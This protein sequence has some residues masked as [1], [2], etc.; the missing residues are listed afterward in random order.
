MTTR[1]ANNV[2]LFDK[3][4]AVAAVHRALALAELALNDEELRQA[5]FGVD[6]RAALARFQQSNDLEATGL[7]DAA[8]AAVLN[9]L[10]AAEDNSFSRL[11]P[12]IRPFR[13][14][15][16]LGES[17]RSF[18]ERDTAVGEVVRASLTVELKS[19]L[20][21][22][23]DAPS[24]RLVSAID[25]LEI[26]LADVEDM[27]VD[28]LLFTR[29]MPELASDQELARELTRMAD[30]GLETEPVTVAE[31]LGLDG[32]ARDSSALTGLVNRARNEAL[33]DIV[34]ANDALV[35]ALDTANLLEDDHALDRL[36]ADGT[37][38]EDQRDELRATVSFARLTDDN[39]TAIRALREEGFRSA[40]ELTTRGRDDWLSF[41]ATHELEPPADESVEGY[42]ELLDAGVE[43]AYPTAYALDRYALAAPAGMLDRMPVLERVS[44]AGDRIFVDGELAED[45][46]LDALPEN[47]REAVRA[48]LEALNQFANRYAALGVRDIL[49]DRTIGTGEKRARI[50]HRTQALSAAWAAM[51]D[52]NLDIAN[53]FPLDDRVAQA[54]L[55]DLVE[56]DEEDRPHVRAALMAMQR[57]RH[58]TED[59]ADAERLLSTGLDAAPRIAA[60]ADADALA[61][62]TGLSR[63][64]ALRVRTRALE[65][66][67]RI[68][69]FVHALEDTQGHSPFEPEV[70]REA[71][72]SPDLSLINVLREIPGYADLFG[73][74]NYCKCR[75]C[76]S[77]FS[78]AAYFVDLM[79]FIERK[80]SQ[81]NF[82]NQNLGDHPL[83]L[84]NRRPDLRQIPLTCENTDTPEIYLT[85]VNEVLAS[86]LEQVAPLEGEVFQFL[87]TEARSSFG[88]PFNL[89]FA[90]L[91]L[92]LEHLGVALP[93]ITS[94][95]DTAERP[96]AYAV[97]GISPDEFNTIASADLSSV[98]ARYGEPDN[99][100]E[101][102][103]A[104][105]VRRSGVD[106][107]TLDRMLALGFV[108]ADLNIDTRIESPHN[109]LIGFV[110]RILL[111]VGGGV[112][113]SA[114]IG[115]SL[116]DRLH[117]FVRL[118]RGLGWSPEELQLVLDVFTPADVLETGPDR[119][120]AHTALGE[121]LNDATLT[122]IADLA[123]LQDRLAL[124]V[125]EV[126]A[127]ISDLPTR[128]TEPDGESLYR[129]LFGQRVSMT[130]RHPA[131]DNTESDDPFVSPDFGLL[132]GALR[133]E[134]MDLVVQ[135]R[136]S[137]HVQQVQSGVLGSHQLAVLYRSA[138]LG[139]A[140][141][142][143]LRELM[144]LETIVPAVRNLHVAEDPI[145]TLIA[146]IRVVE[147]VIELPLSMGD[148]A[149]LLDTSAA[150]A[151]AREAATEP[152][153]VLH[154]DVFSHDRLALVP[155]DL[156]TIE[157]ITMD[158]ARVVLDHLANRS[159]PWLTRPD[160]ETERYLST[161]SVAGTPDLEVLIEALT[162]TGGP[163]ADEGPAAEEPAA[164]QTSRIAMALAE[165]LVQRLPAAITAG[166]VRERFGWSAEFIAAAEPL[167]GHLPAIEDISEALA[168]WLV[169]EDG[170]IPEALVDYVV[171]L[172]RLSSLFKDR[173]S[174]ENAAVGFIARHQDLFNV[175]PGVAWDWES[176]RRIAAYAGRR[177]A[178][179]EHAAAVDRIL[180]AWDGTAFP[181]ELV[182]ELA[183]LFD[184]PAAKLTGLLAQLPALGDP[185]LT[186]DRLDRGLA[187]ARRLGLDPVALRQLTAETF[188]GLSSARD[189]VLGAMRSKYKTE[190]E[191]MAVNE[192]FRE[193]V[194]GIKRDTLVDRI[195]SRS[196]QLRFDTAR[197]IYHFFLLDPEMDGCARTSRVKA[198][199]SSCQLYVQRCLMGLEQDAD[200]E[201]VVR[202]KGKHSRE[203]WK[204]RKSYRVWQ[205]NREVFLYPEN[206]LLPDLR[207]DKSHLFNMV[208]EELLQ[209]T[210]D[211]AAIEQIYRSYLSG[212]SALGAIEVVNC[213]YDHDEN[214]YILFGLT[215]QGQYFL[216]CFD[217]DSDWTPWEPIPLDIGA[218]SVT[219]AKKR[220]K[221]HLFWTDV[222]LEGD[223]NRV[224]QANQVDLDDDEAQAEA[225]EGR[226]ETLPVSVSFSTRDE[227]GGWSQPR[228]LV[229]Y[230]LQLNR[231]IREQ[232]HLLPI[233]ERLYAEFRH[234]SGGDG[235]VDQYIR[236][237][238]PV[239]H[240]DWSGS[241][242]P[243]HGLRQVLGFLR[244][245]DVKVVKRDGQPTRAL[246]HTGNF[247]N[248]AMF[249]TPRLRFGRG[250]LRRLTPRKT[251]STAEV[252]YEIN[253]EFV[254]GERVIN[255]INDVL[256][257][258]SNDI[259]QIRLTAVQRKTREALLFTER[260]QFLIRR[261]GLPGYRQDVDPGEEQ[262]FAAA[263]ARHRLVRLTTAIPDS[264][265]EILTTWGLEAALAP[266]TQ[267]LQEVHSVYGPERFNYRW[268]GE[269]RPPD[270]DMM[271]SDDRSV[272]HFDGAYGSYFWE[273]FFHTPFQIAY[274]L[275]SL[276]KFEEA[277]RWYRYIFDPINQTD[278]TRKSWRF[279]PFLVLRI[280]LLRKILKQD[281][282]IK[283]YKQDPF[284]PFAIARLRP[285]AFQKAI[286]MRYIDNLLD[287]GDEYFRR[288]TLESLNEATLLYMLAA[289]IL[290][291][292][293]VETGECETEPAE[294]L[295]Y[296][297]IDNR[298]V[299]NEFLIELENVTHFYLNAD[300]STPASPILPDLEFTP[301]RL[302][303]FEPEE[304]E[305][306]VVPGA[307]FAGLASERA[308]AFPVLAEVRERRAEIARADRLAIEA[309]TPA[310]DLSGSGD[311]AFEVVPPD[312]DPPGEP[313][314]EFRVVTEDE[315]D[316]SGAV[317]DG[318][319]LAFCVPPNE[320]LLSYWD[321][322]EDRLFKLRHCMNIEGVVRE[323]PLW[324][325]RIDPA[326]LVR[327]K[328]AGLEID[329]VLALIN[330]QPPQHRFEMLLNRARQFTATAQQFGGQLLNALERK[331]ES[332][333]TLLRS[334]H[335]DSILTLARRQKQNAID[336]AM[337]I[338]NQ[339]L[340]TK[341]MIQAR[342]DHYDNLINRASGDAALGLNEDEAESLRLMEES[343]KSQDAAGE[344]ESQAHKK[345][346]AP[347]WSVSGTANAGGGLF[348]T[349]G[350]VANAVAASTVGFG[351]SNAEAT[352]QRSAFRS[353]DAARKH[354]AGSAKAS[355]RAGYAR[356]RK[357]WVYQR[358]LAFTEAAALE[359]QFLAADIRIAIAEQ[360]QELHDKQTEQAKEVYEFAKD[361]FTN[362]G[363][364]T[365]L[366][367]NLSRLHREAY[368]LA[369]KMATT[370][371]RAY[372]FET[373]DDH[374]FVEGNNWDASRAGLLAADRLL[375]QLQAMEASF[376]ERDRRRHEITLPCSLA[377][378]DPDA[379][380]RLR[381]TGHAEFSLPE[382]WFDLHYPGQYK[383]TIHAVRLTIP[384]VVGPSVNVAARLTLNQSAIRVSPSTSPAALQ[385]VQIGRNTSIATSTANADAGLFELRFD[386]P[387]HPPCKGAGAISSWVLDLP[388]IQRVFDYSSISDVIV[389]LNY[390][391]MDDGA[392]RATVENGHNAPGTVDSM[393]AAGRVRIL[394]LRRDF[395]NEFHQL[396][397][398]EP[399]ATEPTP[400]TLSKPHFPFW[401]RHRS[402]QIQSI[403][404]VLEPR[405][406]EQ[407]P[408][409]ELQGVLTASVN[410][411]GSSSWNKLPELP[412]FMIS[413]IINAVL[414][415]ETLQFSLALDGTRAAQI[416]DV[417]LRIHFVVNE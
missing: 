36:V 27:S 247:H 1:I 177:K 352:Y 196:F 415:D 163:L 298:N 213:L 259:G 138:R 304:P 165:Q 133:M 26:E 404:I 305:E 295:T 312:P 169:S 334:V 283:A 142:L 406:G 192:P 152:L 306:P 272:A 173:L 198:A 321:R 148:L 146:A 187:L 55:I 268:L 260:Q 374:F 57:V 280:P 99:F 54:F 160:G 221:L 384:C 83:Y 372:R 132:Q 381:Q 292:R 154:A 314:P 230:S 62:R 69:H 37:L 362:L 403:D 21:D 33:V 95:F 53:F 32:D 126:V 316:P 279:R 174:L 233:S 70:L 186:L 253:S 364:Y 416:A 143:S 156:T 16:K 278:S 370:A 175:A 168:T 368:N 262:L 17:L 354:D 366:S 162:A 84:D 86:Y 310:P 400:I 130:V 47:E 52:L 72:T 409:G 211:D 408:V 355:S 161:S 51:P 181:E 360:E 340:Q 214:D 335:E 66:Q 238:H 386:A 388:A 365:Y 385:G 293:P 375:L 276:G 226:R 127:L 77:I 184:A 20:I 246:G 318:R 101:L 13:R 61:E 197:D 344:A 151:A 273:T 45:L 319:R 281:A 65:T 300:R 158:T 228:R 172:Q 358:L 103:G 399:D 38:A 29:V 136:R 139:R 202:V 324:Q 85:I 102:D 361:R 398:T 356:R 394:S 296:A 34:G 22:A 417:L 149:D 137:F 78:P 56:I 222:V 393:L 224:Q 349:P 121:V 119:D 331:D 223:G 106:R 135:I 31:L 284:N 332:E 67:A 302:P 40:R 58:L 200:G 383:R 159:E 405:E 113:V 25:K 140:L 90:E 241:L 111:Q 307:G 327:A 237:I 301:F 282:A 329:D 285:S 396:M 395:P 235:G 28:D 275:N 194:E 114:F 23:F 10:L 7:V 348:P 79:S 182:D 379:L 110:E 171:A 391:A 92:Y 287:W 178:A 231:G 88:Q 412:L 91:M 242:L 15:P 357:E 204:W 167:L 3:G 50:E 145:A 397:T 317:L 80:I 315:P 209:S 320:T 243:G 299:G 328:A 269:L 144:A 288:D 141:A 74:Q 176:L 203:E 208:E 179:G 5:R 414:E 9:Q 248:W 116:L 14:L 195:L 217:G 189:L 264:I 93:A 6:T 215:A 75:H 164:T 345:R 157:P 308:T 351:S 353:R 266:E 64:A 24:E 89:P 377:Q 46:S 81:P 115:R 71:D 303:G 291:E 387:K 261:T 131:L 60:F 338:K 73:N 341:V 19:R 206:Y 227:A 267:A 407:I 104:L 411:S 48:D 309:A 166:G 112:A 359:P 8:T 193:R 297:A 117:R 336:E 150:E 346:E 43:L 401:L 108:K 153:H 311:L 155:D 245:R 216:R 339:L 350:G 244:E 59:Y 286:V 270:E 413:H 263:N 342:I 367:A 199:I 4:A 390:T 190:A 249:R 63:G 382:W 98:R 11:D 323:L 134:E 212:L 373:G 218:S 376:L 191:W 240:I 236:L 125:A 109:D 225:E 234:P 87:A 123:Y 378:I 289:D 343:K 239:T 100:L 313:L 258:G 35:E 180:G 326:L 147:T 255:G 402:I 49:N 96:S 201:V 322:V 185:F 347:Q 207:D 42:A 76:R 39:F 274:Y 124:S 333:L 183:V 30:S 18:R 271:F 120:A 250:M 44:T 294:Q 257:F 363:L 205:A 410:G 256:D 252:D 82:L 107:V 254:G 277:D 41:I 229:F 380:V 389:T 94:L 330:E 68:T 392:F 371:E 170:A 97:L 122:R 337:E 128:P 12:S 210:L 251:S 118:W 369:H 265:A 105:L 290:G 219:A 2:K 220:G 232:H 325:P 129:S 188:A